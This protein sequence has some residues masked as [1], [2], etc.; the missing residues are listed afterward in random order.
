[1]ADQK[2][3]GSEWG[4]LAGK[5]EGEALRIMTQ[6]N[7]EQAQEL[8]RLR[9]ATEK[10]APDKEPD[11]DIHPDLEKL[12]GEDPEEA[13]KAMK[14]YTEQLV[15]R[16]HSQRVQEDRERS[17]P[18]DRARAIR[19]AKV[20]IEGLGMEWGEDGA[21]LEQVMSDQYG[22][23]KDQQVNSESWINAYKLMVGDKALKGEFK[24]KTMPPNSPY[25]ARPNM[26]RVPLRDE[27]TP[28]YEMPEEKHTHEMFQ[29]QLGKKISMK[30]WAALRDDVRTYEDYEKLQAQLAAEARGGK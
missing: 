26:T 3:L 17:F 27:G 6:F 18:Q 19:D 28:E 24:G 21:K 13:A 23:P 22:V 30:E 4:A 15:S 12:R 11:D 25:V 9:D 20:Y 8:Q 7:R 10:S 2:V 14:E 1:M 5:T 29:K 16:F